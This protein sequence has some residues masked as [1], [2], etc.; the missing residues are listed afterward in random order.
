MYSLR[1][2]IIPSRK[3]VINTLRTLHTHENALILKTRTKHQPEK[4]H[5]YSVRRYVSSAGAEPFINGTSSSYVEDMYDSWKVDSNS[6]H[7][8]SAWCEIHNEMFFGLLCCIA[9]LVLLWLHLVYSYFS[10]EMVFFFVFVSLFIL[11]I[12]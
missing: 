5:H 8:V 9:C 1:S 11:M 7:K 10:S 6:V 3:L 2:R 12:A 4:L